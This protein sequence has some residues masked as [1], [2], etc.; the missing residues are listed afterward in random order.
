MA[1]GPEISTSGLQSVG[2]LDI[3]SRFQYGA[4]LKRLPK[5]SKVTMDAT[6]RARSQ[7]QARN[8]RVS[9]R[10]DPPAHVHVNVLRSAPTCT[11]S[12]VEVRGGCLGRKRQGWLVGGSTL[13]GLHS[14]P[15]EG[16]LQP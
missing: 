14:Y 5:T 6:A 15:K 11:L 8:P 4:P 2:T 13:S 12:Q 9:P 7:A 3:G 10:K 1:E 16:V